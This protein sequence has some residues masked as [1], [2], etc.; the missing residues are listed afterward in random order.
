MLEVSFF[1]I[2]FRPYYHNICPRYPT[3]TTKRMYLRHCCS[4]TSSFKRLWCAR[5]V[6]CCVVYNRVYW[7]S[8]WMITSLGCIQ[9]HV[10]L[11]DFNVSTECLILGDFYMTFQLNFWSLSHFSRCFSSLFQGSEFTVPWNGPKSTFQNSLKSINLMT[12][13]N[14]RRSTRHFKWRRIYMYDNIRHFIWKRT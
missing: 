9:Y 8:R 4:Q 2:Y 7:P 10:G 12:I 1:Y 13:F 3:K 14:I 6:T 5:Y 11:W